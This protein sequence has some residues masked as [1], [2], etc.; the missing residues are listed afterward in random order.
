MIGIYRIIS[1]TGRVYVGQSVDT[2][3]RFSFYRS[4]ACK[5]QPKLY[6]SLL[7][8]GHESH[9]FEVIKECEISELNLL[10]QRTNKTNLAYVA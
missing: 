9:V 5:S 8:Y 3:K 6:R 4:I 10:G 2:E 7:K 1:P